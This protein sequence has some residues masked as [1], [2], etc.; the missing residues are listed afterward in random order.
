[1][2][3]E[4]LTPSPTFIGALDF[5]TAASLPETPGCYVFTNANS[6]IIYLGQAVNLRNRVTRHLD[7]ARHREMTPLGRASLLSV[8][9]IEAPLSLNAHERGWLNQ[10]ELCDGTLP[11][12][13]KIHAPL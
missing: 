1:M 9:C 13:N 11:P 4:A 3:V 8:F 2:K 7:A 5:P 10:C 12:L 6:D